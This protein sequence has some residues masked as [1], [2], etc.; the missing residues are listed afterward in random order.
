MADSAAHLVDE[1]L[2]KRPIRQWVLSVPFPLRY[3]FATNPQVMSR[4]LNI[5][6]R[7]ISTFLIKLSGRTVKSGTQSGAVTLIQRFGSALNLNLHFHMLYLN[8]VYDHKGYFWP[9]KPLTPG[10]LDEITHKIAKRVSRYLERSGYLYRDAESEYLDLV[11]DEEDVMHGIIG[12]SITYRLAFGPNA[13]LG[14]PE[15]K[16]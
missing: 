2:P 11:P 16:S 3:L 1:V 13:G 14:V 4:V 15:V 7:V 9:V 10:D 5:V 12:A 8:G 6:H